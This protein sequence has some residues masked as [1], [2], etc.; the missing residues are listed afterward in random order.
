LLGREQLVAQ[1]ALE[2]LAGVRAAMAEGRRVEAGPHAPPVG[3]DEDHPPLRRHHP[4]Q[5]AEHGVGLGQLKLVHHQRHI[6]A[7]VAKR[8]VGIVDQRGLARPLLGP[9]L[10]TLPGR[11]EGDHPVGLVAPAVEIGQGIAE[12]QHGRAANVRKA[13]AQ[14][15]PDEAPGGGAKLAAVELPQVDNVHTQR[16][17]GVVT[18]GAKSI[19]Q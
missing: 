3:D 15:I 8:Q 5:L 16:R 13:A 6:D 10:H 18:V 19:T 9:A 7:A 4:P 11:H 2:L 17:S 14:M 12:P 1:Q